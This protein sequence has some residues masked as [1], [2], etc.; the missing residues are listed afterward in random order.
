M[1]RGGTSSLKG[2]LTS[3]V[4]GCPLAFALLDESR[5]AVGGKHLHTLSRASLSGQEERGPALVVPYIQIHQRLSQCLQ[6]FTVTVVGLEGS[7][8]PM[9]TAWDTALT[10]LLGPL[11]KLQAAVL[12]M[13]SLGP[14]DSSPTLHPTLGTACLPRPPKKAEARIDAQRLAPV[15]GPKGRQGQGRQE[16]K[17]WDSQLSAKG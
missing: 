1:A 16:E 7:R 9:E 10:L 2:V 8:Q 6:G 12:P 17:T 15:C 11:G 4:Q 13:S 14:S 3:S 5:G